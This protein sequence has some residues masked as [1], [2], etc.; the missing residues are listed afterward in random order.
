LERTAKVLKREDRDTWFA[1]GRL[2]DGATFE[3]ARA[4]VE[5]VAKRIAEWWTHITPG[6]CAARPVVEL[7]VH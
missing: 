6:L 2:R 3:T 5:N 1:F 4:E 7:A